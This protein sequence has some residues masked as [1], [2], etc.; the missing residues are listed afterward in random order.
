MTRN[1]LRNIKRKGKLW[2]KGWRQS[3]DDTAY[4]EYRKQ[5]SK[6][7]KVVKLAKRAFEKK[8]ARNIKIDSKSFYSYTRSKIESRVLW[9]H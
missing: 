8:I 1:V 6:A 9:G 4:L 7:R 3:K 2:K 5:A